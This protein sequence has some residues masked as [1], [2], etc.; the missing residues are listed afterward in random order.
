MAG[1]TDKVSVLIDI[2]T[3]RATAG[4]RTLKSA[5]DD[6]AGRAEKLDSMSAQVA[7]GADDNAT[8]VIDESQ[9]KLE[10]LDGELA[11]VATEATDNAGEVLDEDTGKLDDLDGSSATV[12][13]EAEDNASDALGTVQGEVDDLDGSTATVD[14]EVGGSAEEDLATIQGTADDLDGVTPQVTP[15]VTG[16]AEEDLV[17]VRDVA[18]DLDGMSPSIDP[19]VDS[20][21]IDQLAGAADQA[22]GSTDA[23]SGAM[24][25]LTGKLAGASGE[26]GN[27]LTSIVPAEGALAGAAAAVGPL[28]AGV[29][30]VGAA[31]VLAAQKFG[32]LALEA[33]NF[34]TV[35]GTNLGESSRWIEVVGDLGVNADTAESAIGRMN[36]GIGKGTIDLSSFGITAGS[37]SDNFIA[38]LEHI[39]RIDDASQQAAVGAQVF[40][41]AWQ[42]LAPLIANVDQLR[43]RLALVSD[44]K[45]I[46]PDKVRAAENLRDAM[47]SLTDAVDDLELTIGSFTVKPVAD[48]VTIVGNLRQAVEEAKNQAQDTPIIGELFKGLDS[49]P[50]PLGGVVAGINALKDSTDTSNGVLNAYRAGL[51]D[52]AAQIPG[53]GGALDG[54]IGGESAQE[55]AT[56]RTNEAMTEQADKNAAAAFAAAMHAGDERLL[57]AEYQNVMITQDQYKASV[58]AVTKAHQESRQ[59]LLDEAAALQTQSDAMFAASNSQFAADKSAR[60]LSQAFADLPGKIDT[61]TKSSAD[62]E[63]K[64]RQ[65]QQAYDDAAKAAV[66][67]ADATVRLAQDTATASGATFGHTQRLDTWNATMLTSAANANGP[68]HQ[69][70][71]DHISAVNGIPAEKVTDILAHT[72]NL[73]EQKNAIDD[74]SKNRELTI[75]ADAD[76]SAA[77]HAITS[78]VAD[79]NND[80]ITIHTQVVN[81]DGS[82]S[83]S[84]GHMRASGGPV[85][86]GQAYIVGEDRPEL[87]VPSENGT[88]VPR[89]PTA[90]SVPMG[91]GSMP[92]FGGAPLIGTLNVHGFDAEQQAK[93]IMREATWQLRTMAA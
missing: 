41:K 68:L 18:D 48:A 16:S 17:A 26:A 28:A 53:V 67:N 13:T 54:L 32:E 21:G 64:Q 52:L 63:T 49:I 27:F 79:H 3:D 90:T 22:K 89:V 77:S 6:V 38:L 12:A 88:I 31:A 93:A 44:Q 36:K 34:S 15:E 62:A 50:G 35:S 40:G 20:T 91:S 59:A 87:F 4:L 57:A 74:A 85:T 82:I 1:F 80:V 47:D 51:G 39:G 19:Q 42:G 84:T 66:G 92:A 7:I 83:V 9:S 69:A 75:K 2:V 37:T 33:K 81:P 25:F 8:E 43:D 61:I 45:I 10:G 14:A 46:T 11:T 5:I 86:K 72:P 24:G 71:V 65:V 60:D 78:F 30:G 76:T 56:R 70:I 23:L 73:E 55:A 29:A 58:D